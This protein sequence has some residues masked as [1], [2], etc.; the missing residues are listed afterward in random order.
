MIIL[1]ES[2]K[3]I[4]I[5]KGYYIGI[6]TKFEA[7]KAINRDTLWYN[8]GINPLFLGLYIKTNIYSFNKWYYETFVKRNP[9]KELNKVWRVDIRRW[10]TKMRIGWKYEKF[11]CK[12]RYSLFRESPITA[13]TLIK[14]YIYGN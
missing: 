3:P 8:A 5:Y 9:K 12:T 11:G 6:V 4:F 7:S 13:R 10:E 2:G 14:P 1:Y